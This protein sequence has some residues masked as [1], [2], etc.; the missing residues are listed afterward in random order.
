M[1][2]ARS[3]Q[4]PKSGVMLMNVFTYGAFESFRAQARQFSGIFAF[5]SLN[6]AALSLHGRTDLV[7]G[8]L[9]S[10]RL[11]IFASGLDVAVR[12]LFSLAPAVRISRVDLAPALKEGPGG[13]ARPWRSGRLGQGLIVL[14]VALSLV[15]I[16]NIAP[17]F[18]ETMGIPIILRRGP[19]ERDT[20]SAPKVAFL[21]QAMA[22]IGIRMAIGARYGS[23]VRLVLERTVLMVGAGAALG[24][25][26]ALAVTRFI[27]SMLY[28][29]R[30]RDPATF[31]VAAALLIPIALAAGSNRSHESTTLRVAHMPRNDKA[32]LIQD[33]LDMM[34]LKTLMRGPMHGY[35]ITE[36]IHG[37]GN[38]IV[39]V[40]GYQLPT[41]T[42]S[43]EETRT[44]LLKAEPFKRSSQERRYS[45]LA[46]R[47]PR[48]RLM[49]TSTPAPTD[50][51]SPFIS[52]LRV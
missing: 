42:I 1:A 25:A 17:R 22:E 15:R 49:P 40:T 38:R 51:A 30:P 31:V 8:M 3:S 41:F 10:G 5:T 24:T 28:N 48:A 9:V 50:S 2:N 43:P 45:T 26:A 46:R 21:S 20:A 52:Q 7:K 44:P 13:M 12:V 36:L 18:F 4:D 23:I 37:H 11:L 19:S 16:N 47:S 34:I 32:T 39:A 35:A 29:V 27:S 33:T 14:Q 6:R